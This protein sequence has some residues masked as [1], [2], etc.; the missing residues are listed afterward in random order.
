[1]KDIDIVRIQ[2]VLENAGNTRGVPSIQ[3][4]SSSVGSLKPQT[5]SSKWQTQK[6]LI[7]MAWSASEISDFKITPSSSSPPLS[8]VSP[9]YYVHFMSLR[10]LVPIWISSIPCLQ[11]N[12]VI[13]NTLCALFLSFLLCQ[14][15]I[16]S[17][18]FPVPHPGSPVITLNLKNPYKKMNECLAHH[19][20]IWFLF[21]RFLHSVTLLL[22]SYSKLSRPPHSLS[23]IPN[24]PCSGAVN[25]LAVLQNHLRSS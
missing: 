12:K 13:I 22:P 4:N 17:K 9:P 1:M 7:M 23:S 19:K 6:L 11:I 14:V 24:T 21:G 5:F 15:N 25:P 18:G 3:R 16:K 2:S 8:L 20:S 10:P